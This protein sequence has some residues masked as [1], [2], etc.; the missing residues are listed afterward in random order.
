MQSIERLSKPNLYVYVYVKK[1]FMTSSH[2]AFRVT[3][4]TFGKTC[5]ATNAAL[6]YSINLGLL[7][8][9]LQKERDMSVLFLSALGP[10]TKT[11]LLSEYIQTDLVLGQL[12]LWPDDMG[13]YESIE[14][15]A[16]KS[17]LQFYLSRHRQQLNP[18]HQTIQEELRFYTAIIDALIYWFYD[19]IKET[20]FAFTWKTLVA[21]QKI[22]SAKEALGVERALGALFYSQGGFQDHEYLEKFSREVNTF[23]SFYRSARMYSSKVNYLYT[24]GQISDG[25]NNVTDIVFEF[26]DE[27]LHFEFDKTQTSQNIRRGRLWFDN[28]TIIMDTVLDLQNSLADALMNNLD[29]VVD[30]TRNTITVYA[31]CLVFVI[32][33]CP[34]IIFFTEKLT[35]NTQR[36]AN[37]LV[38]KT[39]ELNREKKRTDSLLYQMVPKL[40]ADR[41]KKKLAADAEYYKSVTIFFSD[42]HGFNR[43]SIT[44]TP[45][46]IV[47]LLNALYETIDGMLDEYDVYKVETINDSYMVG[48]GLPDR[49]KDKHAAEI[50]NFAL[51]LLSVLKAGPIGGIHSLALR[52]G[53]NTGPCM[54]GVI[55]S[56][57][58]R[59]C[60]FGDTVNTASRMKAHSHANKINISHTTYMTLKKFKTFI[61]QKRGVVNIKGKGDML[62]YW[63]K[64]KNEDESSPLGSSAMSDTEKDKDEE[65]MPGEVTQTSDTQFNQALPVLL[66][67]R[68]QA[69]TVK[70]KISFDNKAMARVLPHSTVTAAGDVNPGLP[71]VTVTGRESSGYIAEESAQEVCEEEV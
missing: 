42:V 53:V 50:A 55:G 70:R 15:L 37:V 40:I 25:I 31:V 47:D 59:Y 66:P 22:T 46:Q 51:D 49:T 14:Y 7:V 18:D 5:K 23:R 36:Y 6:K 1:L 12:Q 69:A 27:I 45:L 56:V 17:S 71:K 24:Y 28:M 67:G 44:S 54:A 11:F 4:Y 52:M 63:L 65:E 58:P 57:M 19:S 8:H 26:R 30:D 38:D 16:K 20:R 61:M 41:L 39:K 43:I 62:T 68:E 3:R 32:L 60:L 64:G 21:Y 48:S 10:E 34:L 33:M 2:F 9:H 29:G 13:R 35:R